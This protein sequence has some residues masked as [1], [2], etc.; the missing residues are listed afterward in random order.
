MVRFFDHWLKGV[1]NGVM[2]EP[3]LVALPP[4]V[5]AEPEPFPAAWP[6]RVAR[7]ADAWPPPGAARAGPPPRAGRRCRSSARL[8]DAAA[9]GRRRR[10]SGSRHRPTIGTT[11][12]AVVGRRR[13][14]RTASPAT[15]ARTT[16][17]VPTFTSAPLEPSARRRRGRGRGPRLG[18]ERC[19]SRRPSSGSRTSRPDGTPAQVTRRD[20]QP[21]PPR[22][23]TRT[24]APLEPGRVD[25]G[26]RRRCG[27]PPTGSCPAIGSGCRSRRRCGR[28]SGRRRSPPST[29]STSAPARAASRLVLPVLP[30]DAPRRRRSPPFKTT[31]AGLREIGA[32]RGEPPVWQDRRG[33]HRRLGHGRDER[34]R[35]ADPARRPDDALQRRAARDDRPRRRPGPCPDAQRGRLPPPRGRARRSSSRRRARSGAPRPTST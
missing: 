25:R 21:D 24:P 33:R 23:R 32:Y 19:R 22:R 9:T 14:R 4:R 5:G 27:R 34:V 15:S 35:R 28:S 2:D 26:P 31:P 29:A 30:A 3:A 17:S 12:G 1:D 20:P 11:G 10:S 18:V 13:P 6:G 8:R 16:R 7:R